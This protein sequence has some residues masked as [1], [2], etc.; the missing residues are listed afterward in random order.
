MQ[1][2]GIG[3][4]QI[5]APVAG[6]FNSNSYWIGNL[7][8]FTYLS[9]PPSALRTFRAVVDAAMDLIGSPTLVPVP[10]T[11]HALDHRLILLRIKW[12]TRRYII[13]VLD[14]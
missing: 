4:K 12:S 5:I 13:P 14:L 3:D 10:S 7:N 2:S 9:G 11:I 6:E 1:L 8:E